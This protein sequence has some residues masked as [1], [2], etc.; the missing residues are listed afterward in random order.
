MKTFPLAIVMLCFLGIMSSGKVGAQTDMALLKDLAEENKKSVEALVLYPAETRMAIL[1]ATRHPELLIKMQDIKTRTSAAFRT[2][3]EDFPRST[4]DV[5]YDLGRYPGLTERLVLHRDDSKAI[6]QDLEMLPEYKR[7]EAFGVV[8]RQMATLQQVQQLEKTTNTAFQRLTSGYA[9][10]TQ[11]AFEQLL[12]TPEV[13]DLLNEDLKFTILV[14]ETYRDNPDW[15]IRQMDS[16]NLAVAKSHAEELENWQRTI[17]NDPEAQA[18]FKAAAEEYARDNGYGVD[19]TY[20][21]LYA[22]DQYYPENDRDRE[23]AV[24]YHYYAPYPYWYGYPWWEP[25]PRWHPYPWWW[26][27]GCRFYPGQVVVVY[28]PSYYFMDWYFYHPHHHVHYNHLSAHLVN[29][30]NGYRRSGTT[31]TTGVRDWHERNRTVISEDFLS[32][33]KQL[34][35]RLKN[36]GRFEQGVED[37]N[38]RNPYN[39]LTKE[40]YLEKNARKYP[41]IQQSREKAATEIQRETA[42]KREKNAQWAPAKAPAKPEPAPVKTQ[43]PPRTQQPAPVPQQ[44]PR[45]ARPSEQIKPVTP[46]AGNDYHRQK[47]DQFKPSKAPTQGGQIRTT[48]PKSKPGNTTVKPGKIKTGRN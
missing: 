21:D 22:D 35:E 3:I 39:P 8:T 1:E 23:P 43:R 14:G 37:H 45:K 10:S 4:Q 30:Y 13:I 6:R 11:K 42:V 26:D 18:E 9:T 15:V 25:F 19:G 48:P 5:F 29:H 20:D 31:I 36:F 40:Q 24:V 17:E 28:M 2:L 16:L 33:K 47:W 46:D 41:E 44:A 32:D 12:R 7:E 34:P 27:W 38:A